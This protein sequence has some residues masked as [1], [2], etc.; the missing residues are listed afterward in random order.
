MRTQP[1]DNGGS[2]ALPVGYRLGEY[3]IAAVLGEGGFGITY[4]ARDT[5][6]GVDVAIKE[7]FPTVYADRTK[8]ST[9]VPRPGS[10]MENYEWGLNEFLKEAQVLAKFKHPHIVRVLRFLEANGTAYTIMEYE[11]GETLSGYLRRHGG[12]LDEPT[13]LRLFLPVL[14]GLQAVHDAGLLH[15]DIKPDNIYLRNNDQPMLIDFG[16]SR[17]MRGDAAAKITLTPCFCALEQYP[18]HGDVGATAD[19]YGMGATLY[20]C[21]TGKNPIDALERKTKFERLRMDPLP[22]A[23]SFDR[24]LYSAHIRQCIDRALKL[25]AS[26]RPSSIYALQ[27]GLM[28]KDME[29]I[30]ARAPKSIF[31]PGTGYIGTV[32]PAQQ[33]KK[34]T[35]RQYT[36][37][38]KF[39]AVTVFLATF[40]IVIPKLMMDTGQLSQEE[41]YELV[42]ETKD[43]ITTRVR[44]IGNWINVNVF[45]IAP[46]AKVVKT[47]TLKRPAK[48]EAQTPA[49]VEQKP[50]FG[51]DKQRQ[52]DIAIGQPVRAIGFLKHGAILAVATEDNALRLWDVATATTR[53]TL[54]VRV[55][56]PG[57]LGVFPST[58]WVAAMDH[59]QGI[60]IFDPLGNQEGTLTN[61]PPHPVTALSI[62]NSGRLLAEAAEDGTLAVWE[63]S[64]KRRLVSWAASKDAVQLL[65]F[66][67]DERWLIATDTVGG[68]TIWDRTDGRLLSHRQAHEKRVVSIALTSDG[69]Y[70]ATTDAAGNVRL[71]TVPPVGE[72]WPAARTPA[73]VP[74]GISAVAF[75]AHNEWLIGSGPADG[76]YV[77]NVESGALEHQLKSDNQRTV[78]FAMT[79]DGNWIAAAGADNIVRVWK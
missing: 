2:S 17:Q 22:P 68:I 65:V 8:A 14:N 34:K 62:S 39:V 35:G 23:T 45:G 25:A 41:A 53:A 61:E 12:V 58:Q 40:A 28:G 33:Q 43:D 11:E 38:E 48:A 67:P 78:A 10:D 49:P 44:Q 57:A 37:F 26:E 56:T 69:R 52:T 63:L 55:M 1:I 15:L 18:G 31:R 59:N 50:P 77:W 42:D 20:R 19:V 47:P 29:K 16:S 46:R 32:L 74:A 30:A 9:I 4:R 27:Q 79:R 5:K 6:L 3:L 75:S 70:M 76:L 13:L 73:D 72:D 66:S 64:Q 60:A 36:F 24:P 51:S 54:P 7:Y 21:I 71:W